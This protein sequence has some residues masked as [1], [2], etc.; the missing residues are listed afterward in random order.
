MNL[1]DSNVKKV[2][3]F[4]AEHDYSPSHISLHRVCYREFKTFLVATDQMYSVEQAVNWLNYNKFKWS[5]RKYLGYSHCLEQLEDV[6]T[7]NEIQ[8][9]NLSPQH[10]A[11]KY[12]IPSLKSE[13]DAYL[14]YCKSTDTPRYI[15]EERVRCSRFLLYLQKH[16]IYSVSE[17]SYTLMI[18]FHKD[19]FHR[20][21]KTKDVYEDCVRHLI[22]YYAQMGKC[23]IGYSL[24]LNKLLIHQVI[25]LLDMSDDHMHEIDFL[26]EE[27]LY[28][29]PTKFWDACQGF[30]SAIEKYRYADT[31]RT[32][33]LHTLTLLFLF[34]DMHNIGYTLRIAWIWYEE[35]KPLLKSNWAMSRRV[36]KLFEQF[37]QEGYITPQ[38]TY[39]YKPTSFEQLPDWC[40][41][42][43]SSFLNLKVRESMAKSTV[44]MYRSA[45]TRFCFFL[46]KKGITSFKE[47]TPEYLKE[48]N[49]TDTHETLEGKNAYNVRIKAFIFYLGEEGIIQS[50]MLHLALP[51]VFATRERVV[52]VLSDDEI[53]QVHEYKENSSKPL[54]LRN[55]AVILLGLKMG[56]RG[57]DIV[58]LQFSNIDWKRSVINLI[59]KKTKTEVTLPMP[60]EV[61][62]AIYQYL[63]KGR[64]DSESSYV[65][66]RHKAPY[67]KLE[68]SS[69]FKTIREVLPEHKVPGSGFHVTRKS[70]ATSLL[71]H[72]TAINIIIDSLGHRSDSTVTKY[73]SLDEERMCTCPLSLSEVNIPLKVGF[74]YAK[75]L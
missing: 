55:A 66:I 8:P 51:S 16:N 71:R 53:Q 63:L 41:K 47:L 13:L 21:Q 72:G 12:L 42:P 73:L 4:L 40:K 58:N 22:R 33:S 34:L 69:C 19:D 45:I 59:Q 11:Y 60:T 20:T 38:T 67:D 75:K 28:F 57:S 48:F 31:M 24:I 9:E 1:Y 49:L 74:D 39:T 44:D 26:R 5:K 18:S 35:V 65:F 3:T 46:V 64:P 52:N 6:Y 27:S 30:Q 10:S 50:S 17:I 62:N 23:N 56:L 43:L 32:C 37:T 70:F 68:R 14:E 36:L 29:P 2:M 54:E 25:S 7:A 61:G 15:D